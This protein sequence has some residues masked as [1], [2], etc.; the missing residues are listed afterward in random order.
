M[1]KLNLLVGFLAL[2]GMI[3]LN[4]FLP[5]VIEAV[6]PCKPS[7]CEDDVAVPSWPE[8]SKPAAE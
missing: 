1:I 2:V 5:L 8:L 6:R 4:F 7:V 3:R